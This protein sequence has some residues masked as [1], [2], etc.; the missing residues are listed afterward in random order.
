M[1]RTVQHFP[2]IAGG[3]FLLTAA[4]SIGYAFFSDT[5][6]VG[7][8]IMLSEYIGRSGIMSVLYAA[9]TAV[10]TALL[11]ISLHKKK[12]NNIRKFLYVLIL[13]SF[14]VTGFCPL[15]GGGVNLLLSFTGLIHVLAELIVLGLTAIVS[16][17]AAIFA[18]SKAQR[19]VGLLPVLYTVIILTAPQI[20]RESLFFWEIIFIMQPILNLQ[21]EQNGEPADQKQPAAAF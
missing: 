14:L 8:R 18:K 9:V 3:I 17:L 4:F 6:S 15:R 2:L 12:M 5:G 13:L 21:A 1:K 19:I 16:L 11:G 7:F 10:M 20:I